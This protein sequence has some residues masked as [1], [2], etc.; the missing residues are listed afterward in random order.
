MQ[1]KCMKAVVRVFHI[2]QWCTLPSST[3]NARGF[4]TEALLGHSAPRAGLVWSNCVPPT[5]SYN[6]TM[7][8]CCIISCASSGWTKTRQAS[9]PPHTHTLLASSPTPAML[10]SSLEVFSKAILFGRAHATDCV[11]WG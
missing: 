6:I 5:I 8:K 9:V 10:F 1:K 7:S 3:C 4:A 11:G 2:L